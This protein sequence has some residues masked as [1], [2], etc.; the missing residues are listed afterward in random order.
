S[1][2]EIPVVLALF[3]MAPLRLLA[4]HLVGSGAALLVHRRQKGIKLLFNLTML[5]SEALVGYAIFRGILGNAA[6]LSPRAWL[7][8]ACATITIDAM[9]AVLVTLAIFLYRGPFDSR[10]AVFVVFS[11]VLF[12]LANASLGLLAVESIWHDGRAAFL[13]TAIAVVLFASYRSYT[14]L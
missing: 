13:F 4:A 2:N 5:G 6:P 10:N 8:A 11:G 3:F 1:L 12:A 9:G 14:A 7:A